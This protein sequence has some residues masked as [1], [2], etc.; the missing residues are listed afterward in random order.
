MKRTRAGEAFTEIVTIGLVVGAR[1]EQ[2]GDALAIPDGQSAARWKVLGRASKQDMTVAEIAR[3][4]EQSRQSVQKV[5]DALVE[6]GLAAYVDNPSDR[7]AK[8]FAL[9]DRGRDILR[10]IQARQRAW[11][12]RVGA[13]LRNEELAQ[14]RAAFERLAGVLSKE[15]SGSAKGAVLEHK[16]V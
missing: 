13:Q 16:P 1:L 10:A 9:T 6:D 5:A 7:R 14:I 15:E 4:L 8:L 12:D 2:A 3:S 11:A